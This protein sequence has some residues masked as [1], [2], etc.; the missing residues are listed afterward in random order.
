M[1]LKHQYWVL[2]RVIEKGFWLGTEKWRM[3]FNDT[4]ELIRFCLGQTLNVPPSKRNWEIDVNE[5]SGEIEIYDGDKLWRRVTWVF[6]PKFRGK[7][8]FGL[9]RHEKYY[10]ALRNG[11]QVLWE[12]EVSPI[13]WYGALVIEIEDFERNGKLDREVWFFLRKRIK[14]EGENE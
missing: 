7:E 8:A 3:A 9:L 10:K 6:V 2:G 11:K 12:L 5:G 4:E 13:Y 1:G 14:E